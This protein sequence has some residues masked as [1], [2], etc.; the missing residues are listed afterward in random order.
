NETETEQTLALK[1]SMFR[2]SASVSF[3]ETT[4]QRSATGPAQLETQSEV[5][6]AHTFVEPQPQQQP[7][8]MGGNMA[9]TFF[10]ASTSGESL[11]SGLYWLGFPNPAL[12][13]TLASGSDW[14][15]SA[16]MLFDNFFCVKAL[17]A[18]SEVRLVLI[19]FVKPLL[20]YMIF[21]FSLPH[22][23]SMSPIPARRKRR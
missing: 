9:S 10:S 21:P 4:R 19:I 2:S 6:P 22:R 14:A 23:Y 8:V 7:Q 13:G 18:L 5:V 11:F 20:T 17:Y 12:T 15:G 3:Q 1:R 16:Q